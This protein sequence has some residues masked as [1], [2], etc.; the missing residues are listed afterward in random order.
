MRPEGGDAKRNT[1]KK[2]ISK[3]EQEYINKM[4]LIGKNVALASE[5]RRLL[6]ELSLECQNTKLKGFLYMVNEH[7]DN[8]RYYECKFCKE[9]D[10]EN[11][12]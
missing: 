10:N 7:I 8:R 9:K 5:V 1:M 12:K 6:D 3:K 11:K 4:V 2:K